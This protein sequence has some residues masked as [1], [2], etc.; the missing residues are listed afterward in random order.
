MIIHL[1]SPQLQ[2]FK[3]LFLSYMILMICWLG[4]MGKSMGK[5]L[6]VFSLVV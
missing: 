3:D 5:I 1:S 4:N 6:H 2:D